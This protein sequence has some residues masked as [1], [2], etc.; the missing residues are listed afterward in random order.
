MSSRDEQY[1]AIRAMLSQLVELHLSSHGLHAT[2]EAMDAVRRVYRA[3][4]SAGDA[5]AAA[6]QKKAFGKST[7]W[8]D[9]GDEED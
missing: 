1:C 7:R 9:L 2:L 8:A 4:E 6:A 5:L 3:P